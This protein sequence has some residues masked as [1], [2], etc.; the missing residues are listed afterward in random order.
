MKITK[1]KTK[2][3]SE[4]PVGKFT[5]LV[6][7]NNV[8]KSQTLKDIHQKLTIGS[9]ARSI[10]IKE[11]EIERPADFEVLLKGLTVV[12][13]PQNIDHH[14]VRGIGSNLASGE[15]IRVHLP[16]LRQQFLKTANLDFTFGNIS[17]FRVSYLDAESRL[18]VTKITGAHNPHT[19]PPQNLLQGLFEASPL[20]E[21]T[22]RNAFQETFEM[23]VRL[24][25]SGM[26]QL[27]LRVAKEFGEIPADP[28]KAYPIYSKFNRLDEQGDGFRSFVGVVLS[29][30]LSEGRIVLLD[31]P[32]AFLHPAQARQLGYWIANRVS[33]A[34]GQVLV[35]THNANFLSGILA[36][37]QQVD[38]F[39][40]N[41]RDDITTYSRIPPEATSKLATSPILSS[42]RVLEAIFYR[43]VV[44]CEAD[45]DRSVYQ[46]VAT[47]ELN[48]QDVLFV[49]AHNKQTIP[50]VTAL[51]RDTHIPTCA[52]ADLDVLNSSD[53]LRL[54]IESTN[55]NAETDKILNIRKEIENELNQYDETNVLA[56]LTGKITEFLEQLSINKHNL[57]GARGALNRIRK[58]ATKWYPVKLKGL[59][60][61]PASVK[62]QAEELI[63]LA[64]SQGVFLVPVG[65]LE[66]WLDLGTKRKNKWIVLALEAVHSGKCSEALREFVSEAIHYVENI[67][68]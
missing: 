10:I 35:A 3:D 60:G 67:S 45:A 68:S 61:F 55:S 52:I 16:S 30:L 25:Y 62:E 54:L 41:R 42:Q 64:K 2:N 17:K 12:E 27:A 34:E 15:N 18:N 13:D 44:V 56:S 63:E 31:E 58:E 50:Q 59:E 19:A 49:H 11:V 33:Q 23:D 1:I 9:S 6:G 39:R 51:L 37:N 5:V 48:A 20:V 32:E 66:G 38:I 29:L 7:P 4:V 40:I 21:E 65:E 26:T 8:G 53:D 57:S 36:S 47:R 43:G 14:M 46:S 24:D 28:R 22:L